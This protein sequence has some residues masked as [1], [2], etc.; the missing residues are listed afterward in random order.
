MN[1]RNF[2][3]NCTG[4]MGV[5]AGASSRSLLAS[6]STRKASADSDGRQKP[7]LSLSTDFG[8]QAHWDRVIEFAKRYEV[9]RLV[10]WGLDRWRFRRRGKGEG[11]VLGISRSNGRSRPWDS[12]EK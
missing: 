2:L 12:W 4:T 9:S 10:Y 6:N 11:K 1:R 8:N 3:S 7:K 5:I